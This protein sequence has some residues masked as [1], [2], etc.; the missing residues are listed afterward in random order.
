MGALGGQ[1]Q[2]LYYVVNALIKLFPGESDLQSYYSK[3]NED[4]KAEALKNPRNPRELLLENFFV[5]FLLTSIKE[6]KCEHMQ[7]LITP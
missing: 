3:L 6:L 1:L 4:P 2:Q 7:F 5:P